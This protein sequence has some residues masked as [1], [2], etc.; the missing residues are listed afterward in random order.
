MLIAFNQ[1]PIPSFNYVSVA[2]NIFAKFDN[3]FGRYNPM[4]SK[5]FS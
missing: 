5:L 1:L 4:Q 2:E 3:S